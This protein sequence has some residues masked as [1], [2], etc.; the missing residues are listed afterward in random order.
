MADFTLSALA[1]IARMPKRALQLW[2]DAG[3]IKAN[4]STMREGSG[5]HRRFKRDEAIIACVV[6]PFARQKMAIGA[7]VQVG[8]AMRAAMRLPPSVDG[9]RRAAANADGNNYYL[10]VRW[11]D[12]K[13]AELTPLFDLVGGIAP[14]GTFLDVVDKTVEVFRGGKW[15]DFRPVKIDIV[16]LNEV[17]RS[18]PREA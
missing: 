9:V 6:A 12:E 8:N 17:L 4:P 1:E 7:L 11:I 3:V 13:G 18:L 16:P 14:T 15:I 5:V 2:A 10:V